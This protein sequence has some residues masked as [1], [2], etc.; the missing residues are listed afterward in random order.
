MSELQEIQA[1]MEDNETIQ[2]QQ[3]AQEAFVDLLQQT[4]TI[5]SE[6]IDREFA[7]SLG[8]GCC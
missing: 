5:I 3:A 2:A 6:H 7:Q 1:E 4:N 8:G